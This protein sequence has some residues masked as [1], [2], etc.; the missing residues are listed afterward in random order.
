M[1]RLFIFILMCSPCISIASNALSSLEKLAT[2]KEKSSTL[3]HDMTFKRE[4]LADELAAALALQSKSPVVLDTKG[5]LLRSN[6][7]LTYNS[8]A[9]TPTNSRSSASSNITPVTLLESERE[10]EGAL[11]LL[12]GT[13]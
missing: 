7:Q 11:S 2:H 12:F 10:S 9:T 8:G 4:S 5:S 3:S 6:S 13:D 1:L